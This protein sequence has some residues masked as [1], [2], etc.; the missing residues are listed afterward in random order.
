MSDRRG[1][2]PVYRLDRREKA[3]MVEAVLRDELGDALDGGVTLLDIGCGNGDMSRWFASLGNEVFG[4]DV[5]D[6]RRAADDVF[7]FGLVTDEGLP[8]QDGRFDVVV[9]HHVIEHVPDQ[10]RHLSEIHRVLRSNGVAYLATPNRSSP[11]M[12]GHVGNDLVLRYR[13][14]VPLLRSAGFSVREMSVGIVRDG[15]RYNS[16]Y[17]SLRFVPKGLLRLVRPL[18]P[19]HVFL[20]RPR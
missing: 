10:E 16:E 2:G 12:Q 5:E 8:F 18:F 13:D 15:R 19:S 4:V 3:A 14:M 7:S 11:I 20:L 6:K 1:K 17:P 9:S